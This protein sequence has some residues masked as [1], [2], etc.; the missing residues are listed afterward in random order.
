MSA[1]V[2]CGRSQRTQ[3][4]GRRWLE[5]GRLIVVVVGDCEGDIGPFMAGLTAAGV[6]VHAYC[7]GSEALL[8]CGRSLPDVVLLNARLHDISSARWTQ[9][10]RQQ[11]TLP[12]LV[13]VENADADA[14]GPALLAGGTSVVSRPYSAEEVLSRLSSLQ[15]SIAARRSAEGVLRHGPLEVD[16]QTFS[17]RFRGRELGLPL[18]ELELL[19]LL[20]V[21]SGRVLAAEEIME[22]LWGQQPRSTSTGALK[23]HVRRLRAHIGEHTAVRTVRG[24]GYTLGYFET[25]PRSPTVAGPPT[26]AG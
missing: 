10:V 18:K 16:L 26:I 3:E 6:E 14:A 12:I 11:S 2:D 15:S 23:T 1:E 8:H 5:I 4:A 13:G 21:N 22:A 25:E 17:A 19:R 9:A 20:L 7:D 24:H